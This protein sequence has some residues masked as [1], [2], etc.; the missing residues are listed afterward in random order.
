MADRAQIAELLSRY[1]WGYDQDDLD[2]VTDCLDESV[3]VS[4]AMPGG[5]ALGPFQGKAAVL[6]FLRR[7]VANRT[8]ARRHLVSNVLLEEEGEADATV[9]SYVTSLVVRDGTP[10]FVSAGW[11]RDRVRLDGG[12][13]RFVERRMSFDAV[14][15]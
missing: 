7:G 6:E 8:D 3:V 5:V 4:G 13:W 14:P 10:V 11:C 2:L 15:R 1:Y 12:T 9:I